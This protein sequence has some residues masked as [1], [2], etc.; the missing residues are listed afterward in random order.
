M[1]KIK[2]ILRLHSSP[3]NRLQLLNNSVAIL[4]VEVTRRLS[5]LERLEGMA[6]RLDLAGKKVSV[7]RVSTCMFD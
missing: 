3:P 1:T 5:L 7:V 2:D 6:H 4:V